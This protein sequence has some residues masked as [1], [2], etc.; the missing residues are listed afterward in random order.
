[1]GLENLIPSISLAMAVASNKPIQMGNVSSPSTAL[2]MTIGLFVTGSI[3]N[4]E[5][6]IG[7]YI[8]SSL[9]LETPYF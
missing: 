6:T 9:G 2:R 3:V 1:M 7:L 8:N 5:M 4:P